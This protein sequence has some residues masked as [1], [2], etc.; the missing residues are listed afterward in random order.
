MGFGLTPMDIGITPKVKQVPSTLDV[1]QLGASDDADRDRIEPVTN[2]LKDCIFDYVIQHIFKQDDMEFSWGLTERGETK[3]DLINQHILLLEHGYESIDEGRADLGKPPWG[4]PETGVPM[5]WTTT[6]PIPL[7]E[8][9]SETGEQVNPM[10]GQSNDLG[11]RPTDDELTTPAHGKTP[12]PEKGPV[13]PPGQTPPKPGAVPV[14]ADPKAS[15]P[16]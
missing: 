2:W 1:A 6:G 15:R 5:A 4:L 16:N 14:S 7:S 8:L 3:D 11:A 9:T 13:N 12:P 10:P